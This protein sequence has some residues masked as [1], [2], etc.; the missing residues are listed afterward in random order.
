MA[1]QICRE[2]EPAFERKEGHEH[3][4]ACHFSED[5]AKIRP[6]DLKSEAS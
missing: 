5:V 1:Q 4:A 6:D 2:V 3:F